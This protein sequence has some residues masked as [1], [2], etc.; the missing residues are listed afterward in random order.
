MDSGCRD[1]AS[2]ARGV[3]VLGLGL[4]AALAGGAT[5]GQSAGPVTVVFES[6]GALFS[7]DTR[8]SV[9]ID[10]HVFIQVAGGP[11]GSGPDGIVYA[12]GLAPA[13]LADSPDSPLYAADKRPLKI[14]LGQWLAARGTA[15][16]VRLDN[17]KERITASF[18]RLVAQGSYSVF[19]V[20]LIQDR[21][22]VAP[23]DGMGTSNNVLATPEGTGDLIVTAP[24][25]LARGQAVVLVYHSDRMPH[26]ML[27][28]VP[29]LT[30]H[31]QLIARPR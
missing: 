5:P 2:W 12:A 21:S 20:T 10:P 19:R 17:G 15:T 23:L 22:T 25:A 7:K 8:Q 13:P 6:H 28:G 24:V 9:A 29:G 26:A 30:A 16:I 31:Y 11:S 3:A 4:A 27:Q 18:R 14:T 1:A